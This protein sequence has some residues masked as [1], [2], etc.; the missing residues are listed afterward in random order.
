MELKRR[1][2]VGAGLS[3]VVTYAWDVLW[4]CCRCC[5]CCCCCCFGGIMKS[6]AK[7]INFRNIKMP[8]IC[9]RI[10]C[11]L[12][13]INNEKSGNCE[14]IQILIKVINCQICKLP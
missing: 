10:V 3:L 8:C 14:K 13:L 9:L 2:E 11:L 7:F 5:C 6:H 4:F 12:L 1:W